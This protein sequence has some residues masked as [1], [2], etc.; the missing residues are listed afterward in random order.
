M[1]VD[2][3]ASCEETCSEDVNTAPFCILFI[4][5]LTRYKRRLTHNT[6]L[7]I[8]RLKIKSTDER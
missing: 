8:S 1:S 6:M 4:Y 2:G 5:F 7:N 3:E